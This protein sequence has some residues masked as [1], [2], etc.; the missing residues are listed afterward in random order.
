MEDSCVLLSMTPT[1]PRGRTEHV[2]TFAV[3]AT[4]PAAALYFIDVFLSS[5]FLN[6][7]SQVHFSRGQ[8]KHVTTYA[9]YATDPSSLLVN[10]TFSRFFYFCFLNEICSTLNLIACVKC[11]HY[12]CWSS[13][14]QFFALAVHISK[15]YL[16]IVFLNYKLCLIGC[17]AGWVLPTGFPT[18]H[19]VMLHW[20]PPPD[21]IINQL[22]VKFEKLWK[23][24]VSKQPWQIMSFCNL[25]D[26]PKMNPAFFF[27]TMD[28][29]K[30]SWV[31][32]QT[33]RFGRHLGLSTFMALTLLEKCEIICMKLI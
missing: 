22:S 11:T 16:S 14:L 15:I 23:K 30:D 24:V 3:S 1:H 19:G 8:L 20:L 13:D 18:L 17:W 10:Q 9:V 12:L 26:F 31:R 28:T 2:A 5:V 7:I 27:G 25:Q 32:T 29:V 33:R 4:D 6:C 21:A